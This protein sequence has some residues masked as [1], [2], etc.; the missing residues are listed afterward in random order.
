M[1]MNK[2][3]VDTLIVTTKARQMQIRG[4]VDSERVK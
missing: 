3:M 4:I 1:N 2:M